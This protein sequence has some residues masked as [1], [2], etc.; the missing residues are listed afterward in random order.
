MLCFHISQRIFLRQQ[1]QSQS[2]I[3][4]EVFSLDEWLQLLNNWTLIE[5]QLQ[6]KLYI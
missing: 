3:E 2:Q 4:N 6:E 5:K 1:Q